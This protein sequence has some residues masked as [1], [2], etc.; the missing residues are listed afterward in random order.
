MLHAVRPGTDHRFILL[1]IS[2]TALDTFICYD[3]DTKRRPVLKREGFSAAHSYDHPLLRLHDSC[4][5]KLSEVKANRIERR[6]GEMEARINNTLSS[7]QEKV[8]QQLEDLKT[9]MKFAV[10]E[11]ATSEQ[12]TVADHK[13]GARDIDADVEITLRNPMPTNSH[14]LLHSPPARCE[15]GGS[16]QSYNNNTIPLEGTLER[17]LQLLEAKVES[18]FDTILALLQQIVPSSPNPILHSLT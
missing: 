8:N 14:A 18:Q 15:P 5:V 1:T 2:D 3:C 9:G 6:M 10:E 17:R 16:E 11:I 4:E 7:L 13:F 12:R